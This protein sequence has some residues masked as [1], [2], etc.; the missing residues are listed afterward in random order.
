M[1]EESD[2]HI[3][4]NIVKMSLDSDEHGFVYFNEVLFKSMKRKYAEERTKNRALIEHE[5]RA[6]EKLQIMKQKMIKKQRHDDKVRAVT[7]NPFLT[8]MYKSMTFKS[9]VK[10]YSKYSYQYISLFI[11]RNESRRKDE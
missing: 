8:I 6:L 1:S 9:W 3:L 10:L 11:E 7:V 2:A 5:V 4:R